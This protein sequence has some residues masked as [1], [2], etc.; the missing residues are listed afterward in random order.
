MELSI[1]NIYSL[2]HIKLHGDDY[3]PIQGPLNS[4]FRSHVFALGL[5]RVIAVDYLLRGCLL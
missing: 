2:P 1:Y 4:W 5:L 3:F